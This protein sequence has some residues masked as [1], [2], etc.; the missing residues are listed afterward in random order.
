MFTTNDFQN[1]RSKLGFKNREEFKK[2]LSAKD[3]IPSIDYNYIDLL[4]NRLQKIFISLNAIYYKPCECLDGFFD[5]HLVKTYNSIIA[6]SRLSLSI[7]AT[8]DVTPSCNAL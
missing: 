4:N 7:A 8:A 5:R 3:I 2:F 1:Y 6:T